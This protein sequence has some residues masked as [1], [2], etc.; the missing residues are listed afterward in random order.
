M[1]LNRA[2]HDGKLALIDAF[3][4]DV[5]DGLPTQARRQMHMGLLD[6]ACTRQL[7][8]ANYLITTQ[9]INPTSGLD[10]VDTK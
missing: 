9:G 4:Q 1:A 6:M 10:K 8:V 2:I 7:Q 3:L 5:R